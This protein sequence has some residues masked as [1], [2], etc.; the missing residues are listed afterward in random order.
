MAAVLID[1]PTIMA[2][3]VGLEALTMCLNP[4]F[5]VLRG[6][7]SRLVIIPKAL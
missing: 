7:R 6:F 3:F 2:D 1:A 5:D 4:G